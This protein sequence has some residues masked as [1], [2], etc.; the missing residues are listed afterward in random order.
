MKNDTKQKQDID[1]ILNS[2]DHIS[3]AEAPPY[4]YTRLLARME[5]TKATAKLGFL[6]WLNRPAISIS[7]L[8]LFL[9]LNV[10]AI[11]G[12]ITSNKAPQAATTAAQSF[13]TE[14]NL[15][16]STGYSN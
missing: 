6:Q 13:A 14:Y 1:A 3:R 9:I 15:D 8:T 2:I 12:I 5:G 4:F 10:I 16:T 11:R 7:L